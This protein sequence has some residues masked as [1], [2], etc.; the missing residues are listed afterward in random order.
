MQCDSKI[1]IFRGE[2]ERKIKTERKIVTE[3]GKKLKDRTDREKKKLRERDKE[4]ERCIVI[5]SQMRREY[6]GM[7]L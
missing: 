4:R 6:L 3:K 5:K 2:R 7:Q 1:Q